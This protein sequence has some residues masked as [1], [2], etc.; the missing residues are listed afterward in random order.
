MQASDAYKYLKGR[1]QR[2]PFFL[3]IIAK[4]GPTAGIA[5]KFGTGLFG[6]EGDKRAA[7]T[8]K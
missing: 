6:F 1:L 3:R 8:A 2:R 7:K 5:I 4:H